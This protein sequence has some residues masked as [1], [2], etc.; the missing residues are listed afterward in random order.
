MSNSRRHSNSKDRASG[1]RSDTSTPQQ[2]HFYG[3]RAS[4]SSRRV[5]VK[6]RGVTPH[7]KKTRSVASPTIDRNSTSIETAD[8]TRKAT[9][10]GS[11]S[12]VRCSVIVPF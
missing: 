2:A 9:P 7:N 6:G 3:T 4:R 5:P 11:I 8:N 10:V 1:T 12:R